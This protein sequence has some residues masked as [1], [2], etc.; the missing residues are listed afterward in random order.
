[1]RPRSE[2]GARLAVPRAHR[3]EFLPEP[4]GVVAL[5]EV[6]QFVQQHVVAHQGRRLDEP[7]V[8]RDAARARPPSPPA[9]LIPNRDTGTECP[10]EG[11]SVPSA[12]AGSSRAGL[13]V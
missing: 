5:G 1:M 3:L 12:C 8:E 2:P 7:P 11:G 4:A 9:P 6:R 13:M 10:S